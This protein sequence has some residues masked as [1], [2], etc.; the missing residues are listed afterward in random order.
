MKNH[1]FVFA[2]ALTLAVQGETLLTEIATPNR[3][4][5][6]GTVGIFFEVS[7][8][9][10][11]T[12]LGFQDADSDGLI[13]THRIGLWENDGG[14]QNQLA[15]ATV[16][17]G[18]ASTLSSG[19]RYESV[20][21]II[22]SPG[23]RYFL[24]AEV[25]AG[26]DAW[27]DAVA[28]PGFTATGDA[29]GIE[30]A[31][32]F[33][34]FGNATGLGGQNAL[35]WGPANMQYSVTSAPDPNL[36]VSSS[37]DL[38]DVSAAAITPF[39]IPVSNTGASNTLN[40][41]S[42]T[43]AGVDGFS[44]TVDSF[45][46]TLA[47]GASGFITGTFDPGGFEGP[48]NARLDID[49]NHSGVTGTIDEVFLTA[50]AVPDPFIGQAGSLAFVGVDPSTTDGALV[51]LINAGITQT[52]TI[53]NI[54]I[55]GPDAASFSLVAP[56][57]LPLNID[58]ETSAAIQIQF[59]PA[60][61]AGDF[62]ASLEVT[63][64]TE[65]AAGTVTSTALTGRSIL[66]SGTLIGYDGT[67]FTP[68]GAGPFTVGNLI[69]IGST[70]ITINSLGAQDLSSDGSGAPAADGFFGDVSV[71]LWTEDG[72]TLLGSVIIPADGSGSTLLNS[73][74]YSPLPSE[75][76][77]AANTRYLIGARVGAGFE[78]F[79]DSDEA[80]VA[81]PF[82][83]DGIIL[84][85]A[86]VAL[87]GAALTAPVNNGNGSANRWA[88]ASASFVEVTIPVDVADFS[89]DSADGASELA[90]KGA[91]NTTYRLVEASDLDF[92]NPDQDPIPLTG[93][94]IGT[95][96]GGNTLVRTNANG[97][98][99]VQFNLGTVKTAT[100][101]RAEE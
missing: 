37:F 70:P 34:A 41:D 89:Y 35:R 47:P 18:T 97:D 31:F 58:P 46:T 11:V 23:T 65:G 56:P 96:E 57:S 92:A 67:S 44:F 77:L 48:Y 90:I 13:A 85:Q 69:E 6:T 12:D 50:N 28:S 30:S 36:T 73:Y 59:N 8:N 40:I 22:L 14:A 2:S 72:A 39:S 33:A 83:G 21:P 25:I 32:S 26:G 55:V 100:F 17:A 10:S 4:D 45:P 99:V 53:T 66:P 78:W 1:L 81:S 7:A 63:S 61:V 19:F 82:V 84:V 15:S 64:N 93:A 42:I 54:S 95:L 9:I 38:G 98:A 5:F 91:P 49:S 29:T 71:G 24:G 80:G 60:N 43:P 87:T 68:R 94:T 74:R 88:P 76:T 16:Q 52:L 3:S 75:I 101:I 27:T 86:R 51:Q 62:T 79:L 20:T